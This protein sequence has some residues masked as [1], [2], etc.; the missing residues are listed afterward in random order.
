MK[1]IKEVIKEYFS[2]L[3]WVYKKLVHRFVICPDC[4]GDGKDTCHNP[5]HGLIGA[6]SFHDIG[7]IGC[8]VCGHDEDHKVYNGGDCVTCNGTGKATEKVAR[9]FCLYM[10]YDYDDL[11]D[12]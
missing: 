2:P 1:I 5:D 3:T 7:R 11:V 10:D 6:L 9:Q 8:P 12:T 4:R